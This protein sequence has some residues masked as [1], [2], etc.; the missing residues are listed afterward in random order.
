MKNIIDQFN[1]G[2]ALA[3]SLVAGAIAK[4]LPS[5]AALLAIIYYGFVIFDRIKYGPELEKR[6]LRHRRKNKDETSQA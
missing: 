3:L 1:I 4:I 2:D 5:L 6:M